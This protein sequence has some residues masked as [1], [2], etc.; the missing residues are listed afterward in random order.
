M[1]TTTKVIVQIHE[2]TTYAQLTT[3]LQLRELGYESTNDSFNFNNNA[4][5]N[6]TVWAKESTGV[7]YDNAVTLS[8]TLSVNSLLT[9][10]GANGDIDIVHTTSSVKF[11]QNHTTFTT[12]GTSSSPDVLIIDQDNS[13]TRAS[14]QIKGNAGAIESL[15]VA[16]NGFVNMGGTDPDE[17]L[18]VESV[19]TPE[20]HVKSTGT[21]RDPGFKI[22][23]DARIWRLKVKGTSSDQFIIRDSTSGEDRLSI[24][25]SGD[26]EVISG[27]LTLSNGNAY[28]KGPNAGEINLNT[29]GN[30]PIL[31]LFRNESTISSGESLG[32]IDFQGFDNTGP[33]QTTHASIRSFASSA[34]SAG[35]NPTEMKFYT[36]ADGASTLTI[37]LTINE[38]QTVEVPNGNFIVSS[39]DLDI[40]AGDL[41]LTS[42]TLTVESTD[43]I[44]G[45]FDHTDG[46]TVWVELENNAGDYFMGYGAS[47]FLLSPDTSTVL[48]SVH[49]TTETMR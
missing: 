9:V 14:L 1:A 43:P 32:Q 28:I 45:R 40:T 22:E 15:F 37:G 18:T 49:I 19:L 29:D 21:N 35:D 46:A 47:G 24:N 17:N 36:T 6:L 31:E 23:N 10:G 41:T 38:F 25:S 12:T 26:V 16:S 42:G 5:T 4:G 34:H 11:E 33:A 7:T 44:V 2:R 20:I 8:S 39:G 13:N 48:S 3:D 27:D 30:T